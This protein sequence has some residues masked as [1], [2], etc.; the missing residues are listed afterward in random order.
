MND[1]DKKARMS[2]LKE[3][4]K[5]AMDDMGEG[6]QGHLKKVTVAAPNTDL[7]KKGLE[8]AESVVSDLPGTLIGEEPEADK[9]LEMLTHDCHTPEDFDKKIEFLQKAKDEKFPS[10]DVSSD[11]E[12]EEEY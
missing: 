7:L 12:M 1:M 3:M 8:K 6:M 4:R 9:G 10:Q 2:V 5:S 11:E